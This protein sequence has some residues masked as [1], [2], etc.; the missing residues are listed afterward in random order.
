MSEVIEAIRSK[1]YWETTVRPLPRKVDRY[2][3]GALEEILADSAVRLRGWPVPFVD[4]RAEFLRGEDWVGQD[5]DAQ[6]VSHREAWRF[7]E[8]GQLTQL[9]AVSADWRTGDEA[10][11]IPD[12]FASVI[13]VWEILFYLTEL[14]E[15]AARCAERLGPSERMAVGVDLFGLQDR[16]LVVGQRNRIPFTTPYRSTLPSLSDEVIALRDDLRSESRSHAVDVARRMFLRFGWKPSRD[17]LVEQQMELA[18]G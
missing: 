11:P 13:E 5:I 7:F 8:S 1:G 3:Y 18:D 4:H 9:R 15:L 12:G 10:T 16:A 6:V 17:Q 14:F 2:D